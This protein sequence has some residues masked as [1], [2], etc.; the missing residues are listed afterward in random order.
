VSEY[1]GK[2][3][4]FADFQLSSLPFLSKQ[5]LFSMKHRNQQKMRFF[6]GRRAINGEFLGTEGFTQ[7]KENSDIILSDRGEVPIFFPNLF[8][9]GIL[10]KNR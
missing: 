5:L 1:L 6:E 10:K 9:H 7:I 8:I 2:K 4:G 3:T